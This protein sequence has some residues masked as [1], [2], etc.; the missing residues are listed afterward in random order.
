MNKGFG[1][2]EDFLY[3]L[4]RKGLKLGL[5]KIRKFLSNFGDPQYDFDTILIA[6]TNG[7]GSVTTMLS[8]IL[9]ESG[10]RTGKFI[11]P[12]LDHFE[13]RIS[14][15]GENI[16]QDELWGLIEEMK[17]VLE[18]IE[19]HRPEQRPS[20]FEVLTAIAYLYFSRKKVDIAVLEVGMGGR[21]DATN[22]SDHFASA[23]TTIGYDHMKYLGDTKKKIAF[24]KAG[25]IRKDNFFV[26][27][28]KEPEIKEYMKSVCIERG[29]RYHHA[30][31]RDHEI[32]TD[33][34]QLKMPEY[35]VFRIPGI[36]RW[37]AENAL[38]ALGLVE[39]VREKG[40]EVGDKQILSALENSVLKGRM[41]LFSE[42]PRIMFDSAHNLS[43]IEA[44]VEGLDNINYER[45]IL[46]MGTLDDKDFQGMVKVIGP[47]S[48]ITFTAEP[49][50]ER[51]LDSKK[52][53]DEFEKH[54]P[55]KAF[56]HGIE[57]LESA[58]REW[59]RGDIIVVTG[60]IYLLGDIRK[61]L[62]EGELD[63]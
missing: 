12:H 18:D 10:Y 28:V 49:V 24:E 8:N 38:V 41:E 29:A 2:P 14:I 44:L 51:K 62:K 40:Y 35:G 11:S 1:K 6:G 43:G 31:E 37:Q 30:L 17:P 7:K 22:V 20:F 26:T 39:A 27:G 16:G 56:E 45:L 23:V 52:L 54:G 57:A 33:P 61:R 60:S 3:S 13:E 36:A 19:L 50:S 9:S 34:L 4:H 15:D 21:L 58:K 63:E 5:D 59:R 53:A 25:I 47:L 32:L 55:V 48:D 42:K 46:V